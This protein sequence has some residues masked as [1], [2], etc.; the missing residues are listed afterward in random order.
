M[1]EFVQQY[2]SEGFSIAVKLVCDRAGQRDAAMPADTEGQGNVGPAIQ[3]IPPELRLPS[4]LG[5]LAQRFEFRHQFRYDRR[6]DAL[7]LKTPDFPPRIGAVDQ[8]GRDGEQPEA[9]ADV[10]KERGAAGGNHARNRYLARRSKV[11]HGID[12]DGPRVQAILHPRAHAG[13]AG[14]NAEPVSCASADDKEQE[15]CEAQTGVR[16][17][18]KRI[19]P[20]LISAAHRHEAPVGAPVS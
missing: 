3:W 2:R 17:E 8:P 16:D 4:Q 5:K 18:R 19:E 11:K 1:R 9:G 7:E 13:Q 15:Q 10:H 12:A 14:R 20:R 6:I